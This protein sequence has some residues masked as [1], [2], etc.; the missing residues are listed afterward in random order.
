M[1][2]DDIGWYDCVVSN[3]YGESRQRIRLNLADYPRVIEHLQ[4]M[5]MRIHG[6]GRICVRIQG[7][8]PCEVTWY[9]D[10]ERL[11]ATIRIKVS[12]FQNLFIF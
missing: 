10:W 9:K 5:T 3:E 2:E 7:H 8:P 6:T 1:T 11:Q 4:E 12:F